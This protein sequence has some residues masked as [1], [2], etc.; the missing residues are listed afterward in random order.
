MAEEVRDNLYIIDSIIHP[1]IKKSTPDKPSI[2]NTYSN[3]QTV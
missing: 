3:I 2:Y 1:H